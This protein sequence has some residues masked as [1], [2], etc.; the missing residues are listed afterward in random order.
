MLNGIDVKIKDLVLDPNNPRFVRNLRSEII[1][2]EES[3][4]ERDKETIKNF[5]LIETTNEDDLTSIKDLFDSMMEIGYVPIDRVVVRKIDNSE[6]FL[7][8]EGNR[9]ISTIK[10]ILQELEPNG[11][12]LSALQKSKLEEHRTSF[13]KIPCKLLVTHGLSKEEVAHRIT[14]ILGLRHHGSLL[15][16]DPLPRAYNIYKEYMSLGAQGGNNGFYADNI[17]FKEVSARLSISLADVKSSLKTYIAYLQIGELNPAVKDRH[18]SLIK[19]AITNKALVTYYFSI[20]NRTYE[21]SDD[22]LDELN[23]LCQFESRDSNN[24]GKKKIIDDPKVMTRF[25]TLIKKREEQE[26]QEARNYI[27]S[28]IKQV[29]DEESEVTVENALDSVTSY[30]NRSRW[31]DETIKLL[32]ECEKKLDYD[33]YT[34]TANDLA[35]KDALKK[36]LIKIQRAVSFEG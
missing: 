14:V 28:K 24:N 3:L 10:R 20:D 8:I 31:V 13:E 19:T 26:H 16:W 17:K 32:A 21:L 2:G 5:S 7:V 15:E 12:F 34:G 11:T 23:A 27:D 29:L 36:T 4:I 30:I 9:R 18:Y 25:G 35:A 22:S 6:K 1:V 33:E